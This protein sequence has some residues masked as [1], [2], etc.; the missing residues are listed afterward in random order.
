MLWSVASCGFYLSVLHSAAFLLRLKAA[1][2]RTIREHLFLRCLAVLNSDLT[3]GSGGLD[4]DRMDECWSFHRSSRRRR[5]FAFV[6]Q[7]QDVL[8]QMSNPLLL[9]SQRSL[10]HLL[11]EPEQQHGGVG[12]GC[13]ILTAVNNVIKQLQVWMGSGD[14]LRARFRAQEPRFSVRDVGNVN[15]DILYFID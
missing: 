7:R 10:K 6:A 8:L 5:R 15:F 12:G 4:S 9:N 3:E 1:P 11:T 13:V 2:F 14:T